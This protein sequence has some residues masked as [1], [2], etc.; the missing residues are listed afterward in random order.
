MMSLIFGW[1]GL[2]L[3]THPDCLEHTLDGL[4]FRVTM[5]F[6]HLC[7]N[8]PVLSIPTSIVISLEVWHSDWCTWV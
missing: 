5:A 7:L 4:F 6:C 8:Y 1:G 3:S 2:F